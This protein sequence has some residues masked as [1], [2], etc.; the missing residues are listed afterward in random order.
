MHPVT[1]CTSTTPVESPHLQDPKRK[2]F[3]ASAEFAAKE[4]TDPVFVNTVAGTF[5]KATPFMQ[6]LCTAQEV[7][8]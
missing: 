8:F 7:E 4:I 6:F 5:K 3:I 2:D 1:I